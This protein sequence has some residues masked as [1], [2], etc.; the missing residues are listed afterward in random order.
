MTQHPTRFALHAVALATV[1][2]A[3]AH[4]QQAP[5]KPDEKKEEPG[6]TQTVI[7]TTNRRLEDQQKV[8]SVVQS[9]SADQLRKDGVQDL[10]SLPAVV[11]GLTVANQ[12]GNLEIYIRGVGTGNNT[13]LGDPSAAPHINGVYIPRARGLG[14]MFFDLE[15][16]EIN[17]GP[18]GTLYGRNAMAGQLNILTAKPKLGRFEGYVQGEAANRSSGGAEA[19]LN[20][21]IGSDIAIR[22][23]LQWVKKDAGFKNTNTDALAR[24]LKPAGLEDNVAGRLSLLWDPSDRLRLQAMFDAGKETGTGY[25]GANVWP[26]A[27]A[28]Q[29]TTQLELRNVR[30]RGLQ[31]EMDNETWGLQTKLSYDFDHF[32]TEFILSRRSVDFYQRNASSD[33]VDYPGFTSNSDNYSTVYW[34]TISKSDVAELRFYSTNPGADLKWTAGA[35]GF[36]E[37]Q[38]SAFFSLNDPGFFYSGTEFTMP[39]VRGDSNAVYAD[40]NY[41]VSANTRVLGGLRWTTEEK[42]RWGIGGNYAFGAGPDNG[43]CAG[44]RMGTPGFVPALLER[45]NFV[46]PGFTTDAQRAQ[47]FLDAIKTP[48]S[49]DTVIQTIGPIADGTRPN[50]TCTPGV[51]PLQGGSTCPPSGTFNWVALGGTNIVQ[52]VGRGEADYTDFRLGFE[53]D[54]ARDHMIYGKVSTGHKSGGFN[55][56]LANGSA[57]VFKPEYVRVLELGSRNAFDWG[58]SRVVA[59]VTAFFYDYNDYVLQSLTCTGS[60]PAP[61]GGTAC[62]GYALLNENAAKAKI[63]GLEAELRLPIAA[64]VRLDLSTVLLDAKITKATVA[65]ARAPNFSGSGLPAEVVD[66]SGN[67]LPQASSVSLTARLQHRFALGSGSFDWQIVGSWRSSYYLDHFNDDDVRFA[68]SDGSVVVRTAKEAGFASKQRGYA[69]VNLGAGYDLGNGLRFEA[70]VTNLQDKQ[71]SQKRI[72]G[73]NFDVRF[74]NESRTFGM[75]GRYSF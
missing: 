49:R 15:R 2:A 14:S 34:Q 53:H 60:S 23:A 27:N 21:P 26:A 29:D 9:I 69:T 31:G 19:A 5:A 44:V 62:A 65:E 64:G 39:D 43:C 17:K 58:G 55:D 56:T 68:Q 10:R 22:G 48:G 66:V 36:R 74:L 6:T 16:V 28:G 63:Q 35:F 71:A 3:N 32:G 42:S 46:L 7:V 47:A 57:P 12:E 4:A 33:G 25:P 8:S 45:R 37:R 50:G 41:K 75:R 30:Y 73:G 24:G 70:W 20:L 72:L 59:N 54:L 61:G 38:E 67:K 18:Q 52:Q 51:T 1:L 40:A 11:P 13:E